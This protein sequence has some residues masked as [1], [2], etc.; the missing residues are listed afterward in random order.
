MRLICNLKLDENK[1]ING[2]L[3]TKKDFTTEDFQYYNERHCPCCWTRYRDLLA[4]DC[5]SLPKKNVSKA[6]AGLR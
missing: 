5:C 3:Y 1:L 4:Y 6:I 2:I